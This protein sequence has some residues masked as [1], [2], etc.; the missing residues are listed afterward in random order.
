MRLRKTSV[1][2]VAGTRKPQLSS[3]YHSGTD[4]DQELLM[5]SVSTFPSATSIGMDLAA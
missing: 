2:A 5:S 3:R 4:A 1:P